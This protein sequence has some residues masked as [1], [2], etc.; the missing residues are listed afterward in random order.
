MLSVCVCVCACVISPPAED[1]GPS[2]GGFELGP[3]VAVGC[4][5]AG[6]GRQQKQLCGVQQR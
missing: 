3:Q 1:Q 2:P 4:D 5:L 6:S